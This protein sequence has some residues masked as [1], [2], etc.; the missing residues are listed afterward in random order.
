MLLSAVLREPDPA[1]PT[2][3]V[4]E[5]PETTQEH[6]R[7]TTSRTLRVQVRIAEFVDTG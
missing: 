2:T 1:I 5:A 7:A 6:A 4:V 3:E